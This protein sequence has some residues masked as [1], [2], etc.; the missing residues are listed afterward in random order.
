MK[1]PSNK[2]NKR[3]QIKQHLKVHWEMSNR[4][5]GRALNV[6][7]GTVASVRL[8]MTESGKFVHLYT[9]K[10]EDDW[11]NHPYLKL[12]ENR[13]LIEKLN[14]RGLRAIRR[15]E[16]LDYMMTNPQI[17]SPCVA[18]AKLAKE[19]II[20]RKTASVELTEDDIDIRVA[21]VT[22]LDQL[23]YMPSDISLIISDPPWGK[24]SAEVCRGIAHAAGAKLKDGGSLLVLTGSSHLPEVMEALSS[25]DKT[26]LRYHWLLACPLPQGTPAIT[27][28]LKVQ[29]K[30]RVVLWY[31]KGKYDGDIVS[32]FIDR[33]TLGN[34]ATKEYHEWGAPEELISTLITRFS[35]PGQRIADFTVGGGTVP[36]MCA[37]LGRRFVGSDLKLEAVETSKLRVRRAFGFTR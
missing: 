34:Q 20:R 32:D 37:V 17:K 16:V 28:W 30:F 22:K 18:Q 2:T 12:D 15:I 24:K 13:G 27:N 7:H 4:A 33:P 36:Y 35:D 26:G 5:V 9:A 1:K 21:D 14:P 29:S 8:E 25:A 10:S 3:D 6:S 23:A 11:K 19:S 31:V